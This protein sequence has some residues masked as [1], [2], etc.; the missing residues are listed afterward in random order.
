MRAHDKTKGGDP[1]SAPSSSGVYFQS[2]LSGT[3]K[4][5]TDGFGGNPFPSPIISEAMVRMS[6]RFFLPVRPFAASLRK[7]SGS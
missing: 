4:G 1:Y 3:P 5:V 7:G 2:S 6:S